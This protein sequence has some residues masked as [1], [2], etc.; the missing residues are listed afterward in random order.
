[1]KSGIS[2]DNLESC[3]NLVKSNP[4]KFEHSLDL[5]KSI[6]DSRN[7]RLF[8]ALTIIQDALLHQS[9]DDF[10][11]RVEAIARERLSYMKS[12]MPVSFVS[13]FPLNLF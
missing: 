9:G 7:M 11:I 1:M 5:L 13:H 10:D 6:C 3:L 12:Y 2:A 8:T 4:L